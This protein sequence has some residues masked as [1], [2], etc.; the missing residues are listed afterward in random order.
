M[1]LRH[2]V[3]IVEAADRGYGVFFPNLPGCT[4]GVDS[5]EAAILNAKEAAG[6]WVEVTAEHGEPI[7]DSTPTARINVD[8]DVHEAARI[9]VPVEAPDDG[10]VHNDSDTLTPT[11]SHP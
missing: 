1:T 10:G 11:L 6:A 2:Y 9:L 3:A 8:T 7:P 5:G 4:S